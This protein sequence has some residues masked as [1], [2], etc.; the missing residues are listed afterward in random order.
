MQRVAFSRITFTFTQVP[1]KCTCDRSDLVLNPGFQH[2]RLCIPRESENH[3]NVYPVS[4]WDLKEPLRTT[5]TLAVTILS[6]SIR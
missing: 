2:W 3:I 1:N 5:N 4:I 6:A